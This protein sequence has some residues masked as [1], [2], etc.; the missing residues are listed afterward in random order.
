MTRIA[1]IAGVALTL[2]GATT[3]LHAQYLDA[4]LIPKGALRIDFSP[5][6]ANYDLRFSFGT[7]GLVDGTAEPLGTD[8]TV[9]A[10]GSNLFPSIMA[11]EAALQSLTGNDAYRI[12]VGRFETI[13][14]ADIRHF[15]FGFALGLSDRLTVRVNLPIV[16][17]RSQVTFTSDSTNANVGWNLAN[18]NYGTAT[19]AAEAAALIG[20]LTVAIGQIEALIAGGSFGCPTGP[21]CDQA[22][23]SVTR[24]TALLGNL[25]SITGLAAGSDVTPFAPLATSAEGTAVLAELAAVATELQTLG[26]DPLTAALPLPDAKLS[27]DDINNTLLGGSEFSAFPLAFNRQT[28]IG[29]I[30]VG[31]R[32]GLLMNP[33]TRA[34]L[35]AQVRLPTGRVDRADNFVDLPTGDGQMDVQVGLE[36]AFEPG[37][38]VG[39]S[40]GASYTLQMPGTLDRRV[41]T[42]DSA[43]VPAS[44]QYAVQRNLGDIIQLSAYPTIRLSDV[45]RVFGSVHY[46]RKGRD[47]FTYPGASPDGAPALAPLEVETEMRMVSYGGG[48]AYRSDRTTGRALPIEAGVNYRAAFNG[49]G[50][51]TPKTSSM[52]LYLRLFFRVFGGE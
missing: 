43:L 6:Y 28:S 17:T 38:A 33:T 42:P 23:A 5:Y 16:T 51:Q 1:Y 9:D 48:I 8:L 20:Q 4:R 34:V 11:S 44:W 37:R 15:P 3:A 25:L 21:A 39:L 13:R 50:G 45:L 26:A 30:E 40:F 12:N 36:G 52:N 47:T 19:T 10:A 35:S 49:S 24:A 14:D 29:D 7:A 27:A 22:R 46:Y 41:T 32:F 18:E 31:A 2:S